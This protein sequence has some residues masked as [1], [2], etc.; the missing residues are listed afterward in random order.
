MLILVK[1]WNAL[2][3]G[4]VVKETQAANAEYLFELLY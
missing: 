3:L 4:V 1:S 2:C